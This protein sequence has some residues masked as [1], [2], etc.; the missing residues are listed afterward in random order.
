MKSLN[1]IIS[2][3]IFIAPIAARAQQTTQPDSL[4]NK[5][6]GNW[7][8]K[9]TIAGQETIRD[10]SAKRVLNGQYVELTEVSRDKDRKGNPAYEATVY[11]CWQEPKKKYFCLWLDNTSNE[12]I[13]NKVIGEAKQNG[14]KIEFVFRY[15]DGT[16]FYNTFLYDRNA[17]TWQ[18][19][20]DGEEKGKLEPFAR[21]KLTRN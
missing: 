4:L 8:L 17:D 3:F 10:I 7:V 12:G 14:D 21:V 15:N 16:Q 18:W 9:G 5:L 13:S 11:F 6:T 20:L 1:K 2:L 19:N